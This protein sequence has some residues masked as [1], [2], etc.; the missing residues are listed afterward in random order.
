MKSCHSASKF[1][2]VLKKF[3]VKGWNPLSQGVKCVAELGEYAVS[4]LYHNIHIKYSV[5]KKDGWP[6]LRRGC[7]VLIEEI[8]N[9][10]LFSC[11]FSKKHNFQNL[12]CVM[13]VKVF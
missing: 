8:I 4:G 12:F 13:W 9:E 10:H 1:I 5:N 11:Y 2:W 3:L 7:F 6:L